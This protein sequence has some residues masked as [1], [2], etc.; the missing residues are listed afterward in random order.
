MLE[1]R[2]L[3]LLTG[4]VRREGITISLLDSLKNMDLNGLSITLLAVHNNDP[5]IINEFQSLGCHVIQLP[6][7]RSSFFL[8]LFRLISL[9]VLNHYDVFHIRGSS[10][11]MAIELFLAKV[12]GI[13]KRIAHSDNTHCYN[14]FA[15]RLLRPLFYS[16]YTHA[17]ACGTDAGKWLFGTRKFVVIHNGRDLNKYHFDQKMRETIRT[18]Y[19]FSDQ[20]ILGYVGNINH[21]KNLRFLL[22]VFKDVNQKIPETFLLI[23]GDGPD[24]LEIERYAVS[25]EIDKSIIFTGRVDNVNEILNAIDLMLLPSLYEGLPNVVMEW[26][27]SGL[28]C[29]ISNNITREC[30]ITNLVTLLSVT[31]GPD[32]WVETILKNNYELPRYQLSQLAISAMKNNDFDIKGTSK[33]TR[34]LYILQ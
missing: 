11:I 7:R 33:N 13:K 5:L 16:S 29:I 6:D 24:R 19:S 32:S 9:L 26:Q 25:L 10:A 4:G 2:V 15:D 14:L 23:I 30:A 27:I 28:K 12:V 8:Y 18:N 17:V 21:V 31:D 20:L 34:D 1:R 3:V 22:D